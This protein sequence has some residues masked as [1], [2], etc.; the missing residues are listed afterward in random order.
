MVCYQ[1]GDNLVKNVTSFRGQMSSIMKTETNSS[2]EHHHHS[3]NTTDNHSL[4]T[5]RTANTEYQPPIVSSDKD[6]NTTS[7]SNIAPSYTVKNTNSDTAASAVNI[8]SSASTSEL[9]GLAVLSKTP[10]TSQLTTEQTRET[11]RNPEL[12]PSQPLV[13]SD[14]VLP[15]ASGD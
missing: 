14:P 2:T 10:R 9:K 3:A 1:L 8:D 12:S 13:V 6:K 4:F 7:T 11:N 5:N 15:P